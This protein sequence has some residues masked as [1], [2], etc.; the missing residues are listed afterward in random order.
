MK[1]LKYKNLLGSYDFDPRDNVFIGEILGIEGYFPFFGDT[2]EETI[3]DFKEVCECYSEY[4]E[5]KNE[6]ILGSNIVLV[7]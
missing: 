5:G 2:E 6:E 3:Q 4:K 1:L 7:G